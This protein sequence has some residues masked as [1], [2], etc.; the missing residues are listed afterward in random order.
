MPLALPAL[1][2][3]R[4]SS[5]TVLLSVGDSAICPARRGARSRTETCFAC[6]SLLSFPRALPARVCLLERCNYIFIAAPAPIRLPELA[7]R[8]RSAVRS[9]SCFEFASVLHAASAE[10]HR[11]LI[12]TFMSP[13]APYLSKREICPAGLC[14]EILLCGLTIECAAFGGLQRP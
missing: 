13:E 12:G 6:F 9:S 10:P 7:Q 14:L 3:E 4:L 5:S 1:F 11:C 2:V 8:A